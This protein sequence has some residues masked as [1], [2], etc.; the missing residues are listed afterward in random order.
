MKITASQRRKLDNLSPKQK[1]NI[2][3]KSNFSLP[4]VY[5]VLAGRRTNDKITNLANKLV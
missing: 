1:Q 5:N 3:K 2:A 4:H